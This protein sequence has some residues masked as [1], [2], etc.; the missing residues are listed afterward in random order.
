MSQSTS[1]PTSSRGPTTPFQMK[2]RSRVARSSNSTSFARATSSV[3]SESSSS[4]APDNPTVMTTDQTASTP[5]AQTITEPKAPAAAPTSASSP[6]MAPESHEFDSA[7]PAPDLDTR[8]KSRS[9]SP[10]STDPSFQSPNPTRPSTEKRT[11]RPRKSLASADQVSISDRPRR[12]TA[13]VSSNPPSTP[14]SLDSHQTPGSDVRM[15]SPPPAPQSISSVEESRFQLASGHLDPVDPVDLQSSPID[16]PASFDNDTIPVVRRRVPAVIQPSSDR[17]TLRPRN[18][19]DTIDQAGSTAKKRKASDDSPDEP[20]AK[21]QLLVTLKYAQKSSANANATNHQE[22][23]VDSS[24]EG[25]VSTPS[26]VNGNTTPSTFLEPKDKIKP[27]NPRM[28]A[29]D[30][31]SISPSESHSPRRPTRGGAAGRLRGGKNFGFRKGRHVAHRYG[32]RESPDPPF[33]KGPMSKMDRVEI[34]MLKNRQHELKKFFNMVGNQQCDILDILATKDIAKICRKPRAHKHAPQ[35]EQVVGQLQEVLERTKADVRARYDLELEYELNRQREEIEAIDRQHRQVL[36]EIQKE[37]VAGSEGDIML[38]EHAYRAAHDDTYTESGSSVDAIPHYHECPEANA[39]IRGYVSNRIVDEKPYK[40]LVATSDND[41]ARQKIL[42]EEV[43]VPLLGEIEH[44]AQLWREDYANRTGQTMDALVLEAEREL[45]NLHRPPPMEFPPMQT[46]SFTQGN[47]Y[48]LSSLADVSEQ[49]ALGEITLSTPQYPNPLRRPDTGY[50]RPERD[51]SPRP[52]SPTTLPNHHHPASLPPLAMPDLFQP[53]PYG[54][55]PPP[56]PPPPYVL[57]GMSPVYGPPNGV[58]QPAPTNA[59]KQSQPSPMPASLRPVSRNTESDPI[60]H[61]NRAVFS[62]SPVNR[63]IPARPQSS[64]GSAALPPL[65]SPMISSGP[66]P[67]IAPAP[68]K[69][70]NARNSLSGLNTF[71]TRLSS[72]NSNSSSN[73]NAGGSA[74]P[75]NNAPP[76]FIFTTPQQAPQH[77]SAPSPTA[78]NQSGAGSESAPNSVA[79]TTGS[80]ASESRARMPMMFVNQTIESRKAAAAALNTSSRGGSPPVSGGSGNGNSNGSSNGSGSGNGNGS[81]SNN[82]TPTNIKG[83]QRI[84][85]PKM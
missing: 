6:Q 15:K 26:S 38:F 8:T 45:E 36:V 72:M 9:P 43:V 51:Y 29:I 19:T 31:R 22:T 56:P 34:S 81:G 65:L 14:E 47:V 64:T 71:R 23:P 41:Q 70:A 83:G 73:T 80:S 25:K 62:T 28:Q 30:A 46:A 75:T 63:L 10:A 3:S 42:N 35:Y 1:Q 48:A 77:Q 66:G 13:R 33:R 16:S 76:R 49:V 37:Y 85:L 55:P 21:R 17:R 82:G 11:L 68:P 53:N 59:P 74:N 39:K 5:S 58:M 60:D 79:P 67:A 32:G 78:N 2:T 7:G 12:S 52:L 20:K 61:M 50:Y 24:F 18:A 57:Y 44:R 4:S 27:T 40:G 54:P 69:A 84:L